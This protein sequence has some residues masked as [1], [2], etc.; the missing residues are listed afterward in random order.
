[1]ADS[2]LIE[3]LENQQ[4]FEIPIRLTI[5]PKDDT[6]N[7]L[8]REEVNRIIDGGIDVSGIKIGKSI[9]KKNKE[10]QESKKASD[11]YKMI[12]TITAIVVVVSIILYVVY[13]S[14]KTDPILD[15]LS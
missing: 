3:G 4:T 6:I 11:Q 10:K 1:M 5:E 9:R 15:L 13:R 14:K 8:S 2:Y 12:G 7:L